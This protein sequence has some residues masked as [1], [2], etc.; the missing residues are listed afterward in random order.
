M[1]LKQIPA[2]FVSFDS[3]PG[4]GPEYVIVVEKDT[5]RLFLYAYDGSYR[6]LFSRSCSTGEFTGAK[7][8]SG[9][10]KT[11]E[12][13]YFFTT[14]HEKKDLSPTYGSRAFPTDYPNLLD[15]LAGRDGNA[16][17]LHGTNKA[18]KPQDTNG[19]IALENPN[20]D[21]LKK[22]IQL[23]RTPIIIVD[24]LSYVPVDAVAEAKKSIL[25]FVSRWNNALSNGSYH[26]YLNFYDPDNL[27]D[28]SW[29]SEWHKMRESFHVSN[30]SLI[31]EPKRISI[32]RHNGIYV[33]LFDQSVIFSGKE[34]FAGTKKLFI[35][36]NGDRLRII[37][38]EYQTP[39]DEIEEY[40]KKN[41]IVVLLSRA[42]S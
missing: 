29:W 20:I 34:I 11:P 18:L 26:D 25:R 3:G 35:S 1:P 39:T 6:K 33:V 42:A 4:Q 38:E 21:K 2:V 37:A 32:Y 8:R 36:Y 7:S 31:A 10:R 30:Q 12:G 22:Y 24:K 16:I 14:E 5:Q 9:D 19:C 17:W 27:P 15:R 28:I 13:I 40:K 23:N 41:P